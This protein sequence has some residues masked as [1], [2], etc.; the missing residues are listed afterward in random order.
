MK[1]AK[2]TAALYARF[3]SDLQ[4]DRSIDDQLAVARSL[5]KRDEL[6]VVMTFNDRAKSGATLFDRDGLLEM[7]AA[8]KAKKFKVL[9]VE[10]L[11]RL[12]R[13]QQD[14]AGLFKRLSFYGVE[15]R[16][17][18]EGTTTQIHVGI[19][20]LVG[21]LF[22]ADLGDKVRR[23]H[24]GRARDGKVP[25]SVP[26]GYRFIAGKKGE[27]EIVP[28]EA[29]I[30]RRIF[31]E[32]VEG[33]SPRSIAI[34]LTNDGIK[35]PNGGAWNH[36]TF[37]GGGPTRFCVLTNPIYIGELVWNRTRR[38]LNPDTGKKVKR[39]SPDHQVSTPVPHL[40]IID[41]KLWDAAQALRK[42]RAVQHFGPEGIKRTPFI[43]R[44]NHLLAGLLRCGVCGG[45]MRVRSAVNRVP[46]VACAVADAHGTC[47]HNRNFN[48][49]R[50]QTAVLDG[51][52]KHLTD[53][54]AIGEATRAYHAEWTQRNKRNRG[55]AADVRKRLNR[56][57]VAIDR[58]VMAI[59]ESDTPVAELTARLKPLE[60]ER[61][62]LTERLRL[63]EAESNVVDIHPAA[64]KDYQR[65]I[66][67]LHEALTTAKELTP[68]NRSAF[69]NVFDSI[70]VHETPKGADYEFTPYAR[71]GALMGIELF[72]ALRS[73]Q[74]ILT[75]HGVSNCDN[76]APVFSGA[77]L[78]QQEKDKIVPL[79]RWR[80]AA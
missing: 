46:Y 29:K 77:T 49:D 10:S 28:E 11:D 22:L 80:A 60:I 33:K 48:L 23:G 57:Q 54:K 66:E 58:I 62:G 71:L 53:P 56:V 2:T 5:A 74:Q 44:K 41:Q 75:E 50:L 52:R 18:N 1:Q 9:V 38:V 45:N 21:S 78:S 34:G 16:T 61:A 40:R 35:S 73:D 20:G 19:R 70:V 32:Y 8:A 25:G 27:A 55:E 43:A 65:N 47:S 12:S 42:Q 59:A 14:L 67:R 3:S 31:K 72:P 63:V 7:M 17:V 13:D 15:I 6:D 26:L 68:E 4:N 51:M 69:R 76:A 64:I 30:V 39:L 79:G 24:S 36:K 37:L